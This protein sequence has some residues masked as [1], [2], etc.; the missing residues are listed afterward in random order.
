VN[1][2]VPGGLDAAVA[3]RLR[4]ASTVV[5]FARGDRGWELKGN[6][7]ALLAWVA[8]EGRADR[9]R[10]SEALWPGSDAVQ[11]RSN[12]RVL[13]YRINQRFGAE[14][15]VGSEHL[16]LD[17]SLAQVQAHDADAV[18]AALREGGAA[19]C[20]LLAEAGLEADAGEALRAWLDAARQR[21]KQAQL[22]QL[23]EALA[24]AL[25][26]GC[27]ERAVSLAEA[28]V[29]LDPLSEQRHRR[30]MEVLAR[31]G[32]RA[33]ALAAYE[34]CK[35][36]LRQHPGVLPSLQTRA[37]QLRIL[38]E[39]V[40]GP[41][42]GRL[43]S[44]EDDAQP[45][46]GGAARYPLVERGPALAQ[47]QAAL[48]QGLHVAVHGEPGVGKTRL[49]RHLA[50]WAGGDAES[51]AIRSGL[52]AEPYA[53]LAQ[54]L[55]E[56]QSRL[57]P[58]VDVP[59]QIEL[60]RLA[61]LAFAAVKPSEAPLSASRLHAALRHWM[62]RL[63]DGGLRVLVL[64]DV[65]DADAASQAALA[66]LLQ[67]APQSSRA[68]ERAP[69]VLLGHRSGEIEHVLDE[70]LTSA[71]AR[72]RARR[73]E[74]S[75]LTPA[76]VLSLL[77]A[78]DAEQRAAQPEDLAEQLHKR[79]GGN[80]LF[81]IELAQQAL[82]Q[83]VVTDTAN[84]QS[85]LDSSLQRC[86]ATAQQ[87]AAIAAAAADD[88]TVELAAAVTGQA[89]LALMPAWRELQQRG[90]FAG[91]GLAHDLVQDAV[92]AALPQAIRPLLH[93]QVAHALES[94]GTQGGAV[95]R[96]WL[97][98]GDAD[99][100]LPHAVHQLHAANAAG[101]P[102]VQQ[103]QVL[104]GLLE[105]ASDPVLMAN[106]WLTAEIDINLTRDFGDAPPWPRLRSLRQRV[107]RLPEQGS[108][109]VWIAFETARDRLHIEGSVKAAYEALLPVVGRLPPHGVER[110]RVEHALSLYAN[111][112]TSEAH[113]HVRRAKAALA[114]L[115]EHISLVG[116]RATIDTAAAV[117]LDPVQGLR[118]QLARWRAAR[119]RGDRALA[120]A[121]CVHMAYT[122]TSLGSA[123]RAW[124]HYAR[125]AGAQGIDIADMDD[126]HARYRAGINAIDCGHYEV[127]KRLLAMGEGPY[128]EVV[129]L[130]MT[131]IHL[132]LG[133]LEEAEQQARHIDPA[134]LRRHS[135]VL[136]THAHVRAEL[137]RLRGRDP[138]PTLHAHL[139]QMRE[140]GVGGT[141]LERFAWELSLR[142]EA[143]AQ[144]LAAGAALL[145]ALRNNGANGGLLAK[146]MLEVA[147][148]SA[149]AHA[150]GADGLAAEAARLL[151]RGYTPSTLYLP[152]G[153][154]RCA[155]LLRTGQPR[156]ASALAHV[157]Q[158]W[159]RQALH[160]LPWAS[161]ERFARQV[162]NRLLLGTDE[163]ALYSAPL[164]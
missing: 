111:Q 36:V 75:R 12:L 64:D 27:H 92:M 44:P 117:Y 104:L 3:G 93:R 54:L 33:A 133:E 145:A 82:E 126:S 138:L 23:S 86:G 150:P 95:L 41:A 91:H 158:R 110:A 120:V 4:V 13:T 43:P 124:R 30:L 144:R 121:A 122:H 119:R 132:R 123:A 88:F 66:A 113:A 161:Q 99:R 17:A 143:A 80:P 25:A 5:L 157:A 65:H 53:A 39:Q 15:L 83:G 109:A 139:A 147:E 2:R 106:L 18:L 149:E 9:R 35:Q 52:K 1:A 135:G 14:L 74:L 140:L 164:H 32:D 72:H 34:A 67:G 20:E 50:G 152:E 96:Q 21:L 40:R 28:C 127:S 108:S 146:A 84:L 57:A 81:V 26:R 61:P 48:E 68:A 97:A 159:V 69:A 87:L 45:T 16:E 51:V 78:I 19:R 125:V 11:A 130:F 107:E 42:Q 151:R 8:L 63:G 94:Q 142:T 100:A 112:L 90:L 22:A 76:G 163:R 114:G 137:E 6:A 141:R 103:A 71:Q 105:R 49:L 102:T 153:L 31:G 101:L 128:R 118:G 85:L 77:K 73:V 89:A 29:Q 79:T 155:R 129:P 58:V 55:Q 56:V 38:Q 154:L 24:Q 59:E 116:L 136:F 7:A 131:L 162:A 70:A 62:A 134:L 60:A 98:A 37:V 160:R 10:L 156:E 47:A 115:P 46:L 148:T